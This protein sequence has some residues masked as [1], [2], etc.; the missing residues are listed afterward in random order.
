M[1]NPQGLYTKVL[2]LKG[3][4]IWYIAKFSKELGDRKGEKV[5]KIKGRGREEKGQDKEERKKEDWAYGWKEGAKGKER[6]R[7]DKKERPSLPA[8]GSWDHLY[9]GY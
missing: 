3:P 8:F 9:E 5:V 4:S 7:E 2:A 1:H 6:S